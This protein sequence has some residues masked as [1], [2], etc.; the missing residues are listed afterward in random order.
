MKHDWGKIDL[1]TGN[2]HALAHHS[3]DV[4]AVLMSLFQQPVFCRRAELAAGRSLDDVDFNRLGAL[5]FMH[6]I[7][8]LAPGFQAKGW[9]D[10]LWTWPKVGHLTAGWQW[11]DRLSDRE[12][13]AL[14]GA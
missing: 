9:S 12:E 8:K 1:S 2:F 13:T 5:A 11:C 10:E 7:G 14:N 6:D 4:A 3:G